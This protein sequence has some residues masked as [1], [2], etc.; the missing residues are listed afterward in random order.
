MDIGYG[1]VSPSIPG[2]NADKV[3]GFKRFEPKLVTLLAM[4]RR[5]EAIEAVRLP[6]DEAEEMEL[7]VG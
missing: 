3:F 7:W 6:I 1:D 5:E 2:G 4:E